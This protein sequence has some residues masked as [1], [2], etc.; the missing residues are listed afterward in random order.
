MNGIFTGSSIVYVLCDVF[1]E[2]SVVCYASCAEV[3]AQ[4]C[5]STSAVEAIVALSVERR[6]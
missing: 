4:D 6:T 3:F 2:A 1:S 5:I